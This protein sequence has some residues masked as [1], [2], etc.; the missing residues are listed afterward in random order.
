MKN[1][2]AAQR[3]R[4][5]RGVTII[6]NLIA[7]SLFALVI[8]GSSRYIITA[9]QSNTNSRTYAAL[10]AD[11]QQIV[12]TYRRGAYTALLD[13]FGG[14]YSSIQNGQVATHSSTFTSARA[15]FVTAFTAIK[16]SNTAFPEAVKVKVRATQ[17]RGKLS[18]ATFDFE[19]VIAQFGT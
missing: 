2:S 11:V 5:Q 19:T 8:A 14:T 15:T 16:T 18:N 12:D 13:Q 4:S 10:V 17:R 3:Y 6:E 9:M 7:L 1:C